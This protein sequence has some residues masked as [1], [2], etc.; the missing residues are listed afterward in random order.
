MKS[1]S[2]RFLTLFQIFEA[3]WKERDWKYPPVIGQN[4]YVGSATSYAKASEQDWFDPDTD[5]ED[6]LVTFP[7]KDLFRQGS[8]QYWWLGKFTNGSHI[9]PG[10]YKYDTLLIITC[11]FLNRK[12]TSHTQDAGGFTASFW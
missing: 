12:L 7:Q 3:T 9:A 5:D 11:R 8:Y 2:A 4:G 1:S 6:N 10:T